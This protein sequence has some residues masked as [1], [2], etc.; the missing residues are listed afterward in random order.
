MSEYCNQHLPNIVRSFIELDDVKDA[1]NYR[2]D[3]TVKLFRIYWV[4]GPICCPVH[5]AMP[6]TFCQQSALYCNP[7]SLDDR[8]VHRSME[9]SVA[10]WVHTP[11]V[12]GAEPPTA[13]IM[14]LW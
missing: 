3:S 14:V 9:Q 5:A 11:E 1:E 12:G 4:F 7:I 2:V 13:T 10:H 6:A 8:Y